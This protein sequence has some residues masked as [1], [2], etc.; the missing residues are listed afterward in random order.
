M[1][2]RFVI[3][4]VFIT[5]M[6]MIGGCSE[7]SSDEAKS[8]Q[9]VSGLLQKGPFVEGSQ[10][11]IYR[12]DEHYERSEEMVEG[13][14]SD[15]GGHYTL[16]VSWSGLSE[17]EIEGYFLD[18]VTGVNSTQK[19][20][21]ISIVDVDS[22][23]N[24]VSNV[25]VLTHLGSARLRVLLKSGMGMDDAK[26][27]IL[28][29]FQ[30][31]F[32][33]VFA[34]GID[35]S[36]LDL[37]ELAGDHAQLNA[38]LLRLSAALLELDDPFTALEH[39]VELYANGGMDAVRQALE[40][41]AWQR[42]RKDL[43][44]VAV[45][46]HLGL[47]VLQL[48]Q[49]AATL[50]KVDVRH[51]TLQ[52][53]SV[54][55][56]PFESVTVDTGV[57]QQSHFS[58][59]EQPSHGSVDTFLVGNE[60]WSVRYTSTDLFTGHDT[61]IYEEDGE[62]GEIDITIKIPQATLSV[63]NGSDHDGDG[64]HITLGI[65]LEGTTFEA[66]PVLDIVMNMVP[67]T[68]DFSA[69]LGWNFIDDRHIDIEIYMKNLSTPLDISMS[70]AA[71]EIVFDRVL[72]TNTLHILPSSSGGGS[73]ATI[74]Y[75]GLEYTEVVSPN[76]GRI[77]LDRNIGATQV[78][79]SMDDSDC[80]GYYFQWGRSMDGH[81]QSSEVKD[82]VS[83]SIE[84]AGDKYI[85]APGTD[86]LQDGMDSS[87]SVRAARWADRNELVCPDGFRVPNQAEVEAE[88]GENSVFINSRED[89]YNSF[90]KLPVGGGRFTVTTGGFNGQGVRGF[91]WTTTVAP[92]QNGDTEE[93]EA[94]GW[95]YNSSYAFTD[96]L[97]FADGAAIRCIKHQP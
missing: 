90:L 72:T 39:L 85:A 66:A 27:E 54:S 86:W 31:L 11:R 89:A 91:V 64:D 12:L 56:Y 69:S 40:F 92:D 81:E 74:D 8:D 37:T 50:V 77:W 44:L 63:L 80:Y 25:N 6:L 45:G 7:S 41:L 15:A 73:T 2:K 9:S 60:F 24:Y 18:E 46:T 42:N 51:L 36:M 61:V 59:V 1:L 58:I 57:E 55:I 62:Y 93:D 22:S 75:K 43:D 17:I 38:E 78:C 28:N 68:S 48:Q 71:S 52:T 16:D 70:I 30:T 82:T 3:A 35:L 26:R 53:I 96:R 34:N 20:R 87:G 94:Y 13:R 23:G 83:V 33:L 21:L 32:A 97:Y 88:M 76:T 10:V 19:A 4:V 14:V 84:N 5:G 95:F 29:D 79:T 49:V 47:D 65:A 67:A